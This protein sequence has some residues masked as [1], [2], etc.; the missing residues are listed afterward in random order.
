MGGTHARIALLRA[1]T[2]GGHGFE[3][4]AWRSFVCAGFPGLAEL[5]QTFVDGDAAHSVR[6]CVIA[7]AGQVID[8]TIV[9]DNLA[10]PVGL[11]QLREALGFDDIAALNDFEALGYA[12]DDV[13]E[14]GGLLLCGPDACEDGPTLV[15]GPGTG[16]GAAVHLPGETG[17]RVLASEAG[18]MDFA[19]TGPR[20]CEVLERLA[21]D[22]GHVPCERLLSG[23][24]LLTLYETLCALRGDTPVLASPEA[25]TAAACAGTDPAA[26]ETVDMF[27]AVLGGFVG[28]LAMAFMARGGVYVAGGVLPHIKGPLRSSRFVERFLGKGRMREFLSRVPVRLIDHGRH[29]VLGAARWYLDQRAQGAARHHVMGDGAAA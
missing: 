23:P 11:S 16:L 10:W 6:R 17:A 20:E 7:C 28:N 4:L 27:C 25:I 24:G 14:S 15:V 1:N 12:L 13:K 29:G 3:V 19:P 2:R 21:L 18:Q 9:G 8:D 22:A 5:L 26:M